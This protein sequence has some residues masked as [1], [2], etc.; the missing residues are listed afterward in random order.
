MNYAFFSFAM[1]YLML[2]DLP[3]GRDDLCDLYML[4]IVGPN[5]E[6]RVSQYA[7]DLLPHGPG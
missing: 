2:V 1:S 7:S 6:E 3:R 5:P 4:P